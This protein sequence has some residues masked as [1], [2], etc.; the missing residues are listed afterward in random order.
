M[1]VL[2]TKF[3]EALTF[4]AELHSSQRRKGTDIPYVAH[5][6]SI[7]GLVLEHGGTEPQAIA[8]L[9]HDAIEDQ[10]NDGATRRRI[11]EQFG[12]EVLAIVEGCTDAEGESGKEKPPWRARK[13]AYITHVARAPAA[14]RL[15]SAADKLHN[16]RSIVADLRVHGVALWSR[17]TGGADSL[18]YYRSL[19]RTFRDAGGDASMMRLVDELERT[20]D[21]ME[22]LA[23][24]SGT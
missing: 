6:L 9:L 1:A 2:T 14:T 10:A 22:R 19:A 18:W 24:A 8:A 17:F 16:A 11:G 4:A 21:E 7:A 5:L 20:V 23:R 15:V 13:E 3:H 12:A